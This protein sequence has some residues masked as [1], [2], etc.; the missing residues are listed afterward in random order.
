MAGKAFGFVYRTLIYTVAIA[1]VLFA[2]LISGL[3]YLL[4]QLPDVTQQVETFLA[5]N[6]ATE[7]SLSQIS[8]DWGRSGP[9]LILHELVVRPDANKATRVE[10]DE[11]RVLI[12]FWA[13][14]R[15]LSIQ[16]ERVQLDAMRLHYDL[17]DSYGGS[18]DSEF[19]LS[20]N[21]TNLLLH[22]LDYIQVADSTLELVNLVG[23]TRAIEITELRWVNQQQRHQGVGKLAFST[24]SDNTLDIIIDVQGSD[25]RALSGQVYVAANQLDITPWVQQQI[26][27]TEIK[28]AA[29]NYNLWLNF[30]QNQFTDGLLQLGEQA[31]IWEVDQQQHQLRIPGGELKLRPYRNGWRVNSNPLTIEHNQRSWTLPTFSWEQTPTTTAVSVDD[32]P[33]SPML[34]LLNLF[35]SQGAQVSEQFAER[36][37]QGLIDVVYESDIDDGARWFAR[38]EALSWGQFAGV[39]GLSNVNLRLRGID[40][41]LHWQLDGENASFISRALDYDD[42][43]PLSK[44]ALSGQFLWF[45]DGD[46]QLRVAP[47]S[48]LHLDGLEIGLAAT[49]TP[50]EKSV[51]VDA[52]AKSLNQ[53]PIDAEVLRRHLPVVMGDNLHDYLSVA[54]QDGQAQDLAMV[55]RGAVEHFPYHDNQGLF[56]ARA[57]ITELN[58]KFQ[59]NWRP[60]YDATAVVNFRN[61]RMHITATD[62]LLG[63]IAIAQ[64]DVVLPDLLAR[65]Q[66][67]L[68]ISATISGNA[69]EL[70]PI[71]DESP[72]ANS[73]GATFSELQLSGPIASELELTIPLVNSA[74]VV[75][76]GYAQLDDVTMYVRGLNENFRN[77]HG[78][79]NFR[80][81]VIDAQDLIMT[82]RGFPLQATLNSAQREDDYFVEV[83]ASGTWELDEFAPLTAGEMPWQADFNLSLPKDGGYSFRWQQTADL[84]PVAINVPAPLSKAADES[85]QL[86]LSVSGS[87]DSILVNAE[88]G[89]K[90]ML[91]LQFDGGAEVLQSGYARIGRVL[92]QAPNPN[93]LRLNPTF[94]VEANMPPSDVAVW[95]EKY[96]HLQSFL[97]E[98]SGE[99]E[100]AQ[101]LRPDYVQLISPQLSY[102][103]LLLNDVTV[104]GWPEQ[105]RWRARID[106]QQVITDVEWRS[107]TANSERSRSQLVFD[108]EFIELHG[109]RPKEVIDETSPFE[110]ISLPRSF[111]KLPDIYLTCKRCRYDIYD[112]GEVSLHLRGEDKLLEL[113]DFNAQ[114]RNH[115]LKASGTWALETETQHPQT[116]IFGEFTS[117]DFGEFLE[118]YEFTSMVRD[119][120]ATIAFDLSYLGAPQQIQATSLNGTVNWRL[121]QGYLNEVSDRGARLFSLLSLD[122]ILRKLRFDFRDV[123]ANGLFYT[124]FS[125][126]FNIVNG[127]V[128]TENTQLNGAAGDMEVKGQTNLMTRTLDYDLQFVPKVTSSLPVILAWMINP[129]SGL[130][131]LVIDRMLHDAKVISRLEYKISGTM[132]EPQIEEIARDSRDAPIPPEV[133]N[134]PESEQ[135]PSSTDGAANDE[136]PASATEPTGN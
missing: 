74:D 75:A 6:Y 55:W 40:N 64:A 12:D 51:H 5:S 129:P 104:V 17:R 103:D 131:A 85:E 37:T 134:E 59:P 82:W 108:A 81:D 112:L 113:V 36:D 21:L 43:W 24:V 135:Q 125:G 41:Q 124:N 29:F 98:G 120:N 10:I 111:A 100:L 22:Q 20:P 89:E 3:R 26:I 84:Q 80:N 132:D 78:R 52:V 50:S 49:L 30:K 94:T 38:G 90:M 136:Q 44:V 105:D 11:A 54:L 27:D 19:R 99:S 87:E 115:T 48:E 39:P 18:T 14:A 106:S 114:H 93:V 9:E 110:E 32:L 92:T 61:E 60:I 97:P 4:P 46:W 101:L 83:D 56:E 79:V 35:G 53:Q 91:E 57:R 58:Y 96:H 72:L 31:L 28:K 117:P 86:E 107:A 116:R 1:L 16:F 63:N 126:D 25:T 77:V 69:N 65:E 67:R 121:G 66:A 2:L 71:F 34:E 128:S 95:L 133:Q 13:S 47:Q 42:P 88:L 123:F 119:S 130:A 62:G 102:G 23:V 76:Q 73:L 45:E 109:K 127:I 8:A 33:L 68:D 70:K 118:N 7:V 122:S 15:S